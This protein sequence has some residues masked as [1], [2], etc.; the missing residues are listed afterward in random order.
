M[1]GWRGLRASSLKHEPADRPELMTW[2][3]FGRE[4]SLVSG[5]GASV[6][7]LLQVAGPMTMLPQ[8]GAVLVKTPAQETDGLGFD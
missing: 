5:L 8:A 3:Q 2:R 6:P 7:S 1:G 4:G